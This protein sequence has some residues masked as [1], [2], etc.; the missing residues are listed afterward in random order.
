[1]MA[2]RLARTLKILFLF[3]V[4]ATGIAFHSCMSFRMSATEVDSYFRE[5]NV[6]ATQHVYET[7][8]REIHYV[9]A[10]DSTRA[11]V[12]RSPGDAVPKLVIAAIIARIK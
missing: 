6:H 2:W 8:S 12:P 4:L 5:R 9:S 11:L 3:I 10:G 1:M 7:G